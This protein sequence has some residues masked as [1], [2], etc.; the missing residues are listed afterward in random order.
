[1]KVEPGAA[2]ESETPAEP[3]AAPVCR[4]CG[5]SLD[6]GAGADEVVTLCA[7]GAITSCTFPACLARRAQAAAHDLAPP[8]DPAPEVI[9]LASTL[10]RIVVR[11]L[12]GGR[13]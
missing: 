5:A 12:G 4:F 6:P 13:E 8:S 11:T 3:Q 1:R 9:S 7:D 10:W 2:S